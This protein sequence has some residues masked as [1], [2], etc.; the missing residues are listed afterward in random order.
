VSSAADDRDL[1]DIRPPDHSGGDTGMDCFGTALRQ[2]AQS[3]V[4]IDIRAR[5]PDRRT[6]Q[7]PW[8]TYPATYWTA[9]AHEEGGHRRFSL[10]TLAFVGDAQHRLRAE[11]RSAAARVDPYLTG[12]DLL[13]RTIHPDDKPIA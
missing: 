12:R 8:P 13:P 9:P 2:R 10:P 3:V 1:Q 6:P 4:H 7:M 5:P 11:G